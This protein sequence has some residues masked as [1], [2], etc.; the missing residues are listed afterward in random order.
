MTDHDFELRLRDDLRK[1]P[2]PARA[3]LRAS[4]IAIPDEVPSSLGRRLTPGWTFPALLRFA[5]LG[6]AAAAVLVVVLIGS[7]LLVSSGSSLTGS[8]KSNG[9]CGSGPRCAKW[10]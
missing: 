3:A 8:R 10:G 9:F 7:G 4:V 6:L 5:A 2:E 1:L